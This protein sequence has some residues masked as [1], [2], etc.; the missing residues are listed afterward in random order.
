MNKYREAAERILKN[1]QYTLLT[2]KSGNEVWENANCEI[3]HCGNDKSSSYAFDIAIMPMGIAVTGDIGEY[4]FDV[5]GRGMDFL[6]GK[7]V[8][9][10]IHSKLSRHCKEEE[11]IYEKFEDT[12]KDYVLT[13][14]ENN[15]DLNYE[16]A[17]DLLEDCREKDFNHLKKYI[18]IVYFDTEKELD[19]ETEKFVDN[20]YNFFETVT[21]VSYNQEA[22]ELLCN[23]SF[24]EFTDSFECYFIDVSGSLMRSLYMINYAAQQIMKIKNEMS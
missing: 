1:H 16:F 14:F 10:Y 9:Y 18:E 2:Q 19:N 24:M 5:Y 17:V 21:T 13:E 11:F 12:V 23:C 20:L 22:H 15:D 7:D 3:W 6:A 8:G 4:T